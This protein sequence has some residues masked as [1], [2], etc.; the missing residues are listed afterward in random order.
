[1]DGPRRGC[2]LAVLLAAL[3]AG[4]GS[5]TAQVN[6]GFSVGINSSS[7]SGDKPPDV[8]YTSSTNLLANVVA[9]FRIADDVWISVQPG[10][11][12]RGAGLAFKVDGEEEP[13]DSLTLNMNYLSVPVLMKVVTGKKVYVTG[14]LDF[15]YLLNAELA[16]NGGGEGV[17]LRDAIKNASVGFI[18]GVG[19]MFPIGRPRI[20]VEGRYT[21]S[22]TNDAEP[23]RSDAGGQDLPVRFRS[24]GLQ[25]L[26]G[27]LIPLGG[28]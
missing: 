26:V 28:P 24:T 18:F 1:M 21:Q 22:L 2:L 4:P 23:E 11:A 13:R 14:G 15:S 8:S 3:G 6:L 25:L 9:D 16:P 7:L 12:G 17:D 20:T 27:F 5:A 19:A 10:Y